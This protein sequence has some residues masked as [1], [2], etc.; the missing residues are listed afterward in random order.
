MV[1][2]GKKKLADHFTKKTNAPKETFQF[3]FQSSE[4]T[5]VEAPNKV[6]NSSVDTITK[7][8]ENTTLTDTNSNK[9][10]KKKKKKNAKKAKEIKAIEEPVSTEFK[11]LFTFYQTGFTEAELAE[12][13][14]E[15]KKKAA[16][17]WAKKKKTASTASTPAPEPQ[18]PAGT[19]NFVTLRKA[20]DNSSEVQKMQLRYG[21]GKRIQTNP[22]KKKVDPAPSTFMFNF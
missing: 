15:P 1:G 8:L 10:K 20:T 19:T 11:F 14:P 17:P 16:K 18:N 4:S 3:S 13:A 9:K 22:V 21:K 7:E 6:S 5:R 2:T 12:I